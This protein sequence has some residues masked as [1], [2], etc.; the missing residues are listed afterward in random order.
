MSYLREDPKLQS[1][2]QL[3]WLGR[4]TQ[5]SEGSK[6][7]KGSEGSMCSKANRGLVKQYC[8]PIHIQSGSSIQHIPPDEFGNWTALLK[9]SCQL[10]RRHCLLR[11]ASLKALLQS[12][13]L[14]H[15][16]LEALL[17]SMPLFYH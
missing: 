13:L 10:R 17:Q 6:G 16:G 11:Q 15:L 7:S 3:G 2:R 5:G 9:L 1:F 14:L 12:M 4:A 8:K